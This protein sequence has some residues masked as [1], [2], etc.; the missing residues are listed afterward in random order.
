MIR[1][2]LGWTVGVFLSSGLLVS[3]RPMAD[4][5][6]TYTRP[7]RANKCGRSCILSISLGVVWSG[8]LCAME[9][10]DG[11]CTDPMCVMFVVGSILD[12]LEDSVA[13]L[14]VAVVI[15]CDDGRISG[16]STIGGT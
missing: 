6:R 2:E 12:A 14:G 15:G 7:D 10:R 13:I 9:G 16:L 8:C 4:L 5:L 1:R 3:S 11:C